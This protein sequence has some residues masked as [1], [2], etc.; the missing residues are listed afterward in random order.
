M[1]R[2]LFALLV[3]VLVAEAN[4]KASKGLHKITILHRCDMF[5]ETENTAGDMCKV[6]LLTLNVCFFFAQHR[7]QL[8]QVVCYQTDFK[9]NSWR[10]EWK[11]I[12]D[13]NTAYCRSFIRPIWLMLINKQIHSKKFVKGYSCENREHLLEI[14][15]ILRFGQIWANGQI[16]IERNKVLD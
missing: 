2:N 12:F 4:R 1:K 11:T 7:C 8:Q 5:A 14:L 3:S 9:R 16:L 15:G 13:N 6:S 10:S